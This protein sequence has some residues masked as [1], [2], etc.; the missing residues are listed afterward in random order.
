MDALFSITSDCTT[1]DTMAR[2]LILLVF[3]TLF[4]IAASAEAILF[5]PPDSLAPYEPVPVAEQAPFAADADL[6]S[7]DFLDRGAADC[8]LLR[9]GG[10]TMLVDGGKYQLIDHLLDVFSHLEITHFTY[11]LNTHAHDD[12]IEGLIGLLRRDYTPDLYMSCYPDDYAGSP[13]QTRVREL[14]REK[15]VPYRKIGDGVQFTLGGASLTVYRDET[16]SIDKNRHSILLKVV[17]GKRSALLMADAGGQTQ[18]YLLTQ[19]DPDVF[20]ADVLKYPHHGYV[21]MEPAFLSAVDP[22]LC[23]VTNTRSSAALAEKQLS[24]RGIPRFFT[25]QGAV[26]LQT[27]G[28][29]W[30]AQQ[31]PFAWPLDAP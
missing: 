7:I 13:Y 8:I 9:C 1:G 24:Q 29:S 23:V 6:L 12:H 2:K 4:P 17:F 28:L 31:M 25:N 10:E 11:M 20:K 26:R 15:D 21:H 18:D 16:P 22:L 3:L 19:Y 14:L 30:Y 27:D 5:Y